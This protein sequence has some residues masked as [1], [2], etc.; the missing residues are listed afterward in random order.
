LRVN[1]YQ[2]SIASNRTFSTEVTLADQDEVTVT[3]EALNAQ[4]SVLQTVTRQLKRNRTPPASPTITSPAREGQTY[5]TQR[6]EMVMRGTA[7]ADAAGIIVN[8]YR[9][10]LFKPGSG[11]WS[12]LASTR[13]GN[14]HEGEN[15]FTVYS[16]NEG[17]LMSPAVS[18]T[19]ILGGEGEGVV[20]SAAASG[21]Q[22]EVAEE[23][24]PKNEP[25]MPGTLAV[26]APAAGTA[27]TAGTGSF[28]LEG[29]TSPK[30]SS[31][32]VN[33][34]RLRLYVP[35]KTFWN[36]IADEKLGTL[37]K[38]VNTYVINARDSESKIL[39]TLTYTVTYE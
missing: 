38:G 23:S 16:V 12:Y 5:R 31:V 20:S 22:V 32:W 15:I 4:G 10:Q 39:D 13:L 11:E 37:K 30:T 7:A 2:V 6:T 34:Y 8:D 24:L 35:G 17:G 27:F 9:L 1:G 3:I 25:L 26:T 19:I 33:G 18:L 28:L 36:Y 29:T 21:S 14:F